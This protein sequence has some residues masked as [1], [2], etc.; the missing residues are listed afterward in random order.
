MT[1]L[2]IFYDYACP[3]CFRAHESLKEL[4]ADYPDIEIVWI[5]CEAH[6]RPEKRSPH[7]DLC[8]R[9]LYIARDLNAD[10]WAYHDAAYAAAV[11]NRVNIDDPAV[12]AKAAGGAVDSAAFLS[13]LKS[14]SHADKPDG[15]NDYAYEKSGVWAVPAYRM[16]GKKLDA[17]EGIGVTK[18]ALAAFLS[19]A[20]K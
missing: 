10:V 1:K 9:G 6:P 13:A 5:P 4:Y 12:L 20:G 14:G 16:N 2:E 19:A 17:L 7:S 11:K 15:N 3:Y 8:L 18:P